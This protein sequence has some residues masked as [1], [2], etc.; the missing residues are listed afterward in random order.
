MSKSWI[1]WQKVHECSQEIPKFPRMLI[2]AKSCHKWQKWQKYDYSGKRKPKVGKNMPKDA[3]CCKNMTKVAIFWMP[4]WSW[5]IVFCLMYTG[6]NASNPKLCPACD[7]LTHSLT[8]VKSRD[9]SA[10]KKKDKG[11]DNSKHEAGLT[12]SPPTSFMA[13]MTKGMYQKHVHSD[14]IAQLHF[15]KDEEI[16]GVI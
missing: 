11:K 3:K 15:W 7:S 2:V 13:G 5:S 14:Q 4:K 8:R 10:S 9:A 1:K 12:V 6:L 16:N